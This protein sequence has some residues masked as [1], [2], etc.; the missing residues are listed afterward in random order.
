MG[1]VNDFDK[2]E[3]GGWKSAA[4]SSG[5]AA[6]HL[7]ATPGPQIPVARANSPRLH[8]GL[9]VLECLTPEFTDSCRIR[10]TVA[11]TG[12]EEEQ[13]KN[14]SI[15]IE[16]CSLGRPSGIRLI[17]PKRVSGFENGYGV[18][19]FFSTHPPA[20]Y[21]RRFS[22]LMQAAFP[23]HVPTTA[24]SIRAISHSGEHAKKAIRWLEWLLRSLS[25]VGKPPTRMT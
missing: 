24:T 9:G 15:R 22:R 5:R 12:E 23:S 1:Q 2:M 21:G 13:R 11:G 18:D 19:F 16:I 14:V 6:P 8:C 4:L 20:I 3:W 7:K 25:N 10:Q 17:P